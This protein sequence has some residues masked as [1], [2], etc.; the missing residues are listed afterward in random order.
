MDIEHI[1][2]VA[3]NCDLHNKIF[4]EKVWILIVCIN[5]LRVPTKSFKVYHYFRKNFYLVNYGCFTNGQSPKESH[6]ENND[7]N[8]TGTM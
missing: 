7:K 2:E 3:P 5:Q 4:G 1:I 6:S 8:K